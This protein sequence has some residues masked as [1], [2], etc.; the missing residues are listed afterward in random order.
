MLEKIAGFIESVHSVCSHNRHKG[1]RSSCGVII[2]PYFKYSLE[3]I[4][5]VSFGPVAMISGKLY[6]HKSTALEIDYRIFI[7]G[8][9]RLRSYWK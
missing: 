2:N 1:N 5:T 8:R 4:Q 6:F 7:I 3:C 9:M